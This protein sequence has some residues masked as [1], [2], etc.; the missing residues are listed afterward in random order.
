VDDADS[1]REFDDD[2]LNQ[3]LLVFRDLN[4]HE[5]RSIIPRSTIGRIVAHGPEL[6]LD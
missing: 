5:S 3:Q 4:P 2:G 1:L 6:V